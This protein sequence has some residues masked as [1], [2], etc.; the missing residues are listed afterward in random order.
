M[1]QVLKRDGKIVEFDITKIA[2]AI[3]AAFKGQN[4]QYHPSVISMLALRVTSDFEPKIKDGKIT[5]EDIQD[6]VE[7][8]LV[9]AGYADVAKAYILYRKQREKVR[10]VRA[11]ILN[12]KE[13]VD[14]YVKVSDWRVK[15]NSTVTYSVGGLI[16]SNSGAITAN[17]WLSEIYDEEVAN[18]HR[19]ADIHLHDLS[20]LTG[21]C[22]GWSLKQLIREGLGGVTGKIT[23]G[24]AAEAFAA[25]PARSLPP[26]QSTS[27]PSAT[28]WLTSSVSCR[29]NGRARKPSPL[30]IP[31]SLL[32]S[33]S[34]IF[35]T[36]TLKSASKAL[37]SASTPPLV[38]VRK[39]RSVTS[40]STGWS[41]TT[42]PNSRPSSA[43][44]I[45]TSATKIAKKKWI[46]STKPS[47]KR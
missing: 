42:S 27:P 6:S 9:Q 14:S 46:W 40:P 18:A 4:K 41:R 5:V 21:Y 24:D 31:T 16:L 36:A 28:R 22:A 33:R 44:R 15:E 30:S 29:T 38:G 10:N 19:N 8:V 3:E 7:S 2:N 13:L 23:S 1:Y 43:A 26:R 47:S 20:M 17:Y 25:S 11:N 45:W 39:H 35:R 37:S 12:Y 32:S 34:T